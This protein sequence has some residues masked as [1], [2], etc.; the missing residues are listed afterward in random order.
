MIINY[1]SVEKADQ[2]IALRLLSERGK[3]GHFF[4]SVKN[5]QVKSLPS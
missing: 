5:I 3:S 2:A 4:I 1:V